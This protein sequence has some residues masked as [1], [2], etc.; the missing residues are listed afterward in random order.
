MSTVDGPPAETGPAQPEAEAPWAAPGAQ[1]PGAQAPWAAPGAQP[2]W[3]APGAPG[4]WGPG[5]TWGP[6]GPAGPAGP[7][8]AWGPGG[9]GGAGDPGSWGAEPGGPARRPHRRRNAVV[10]AGVAGVLAAGGTAWAVAASAGTPVLSTAVIASK[11]DPGLVDVVSTLGYQQAT[12]EG[13]GMVLTSTGEVLTNNHV[14]SGATSIKVI[15]IGNGRTYTAKVVG[16]SESNDVAVL[17]LQNASGLAT[18]SPGDSSTVR[19]G[20]KVVALGNA[21]GKGGTPSVATGT[22]SSLGSSITAVDSGDGVS[23]HLSGMIRSDAGIEP[24]DSGGPLVNTAGQVIG[25]DTAASTSGAEPGATS[26]TSAAASSSTEAFSIPINEALSVA[27][28]IAAGQSSATVHIGSTAFLGVA[29]A[30]GGQS[31][32][33]GGQSGAFGGQSGEFGGQAATGAAVEGSLPGTAAAQAGLGAGD[34]ITSL[35]GRAI[36][37]QSDL[38]S[39]VEAYHPG[40]KVSVSWTDSSGQAQTATVVLTAGPAG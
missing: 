26:A 33:F 27:G 2:P 14:I 8:G 13:T 6:G 21:E 39:A 32:A 12:S 4:P 34:V 37:S 10:A 20:Q 40:S 31:G 28:Q 7:A 22:V 3:A 15:D 23:E 38:Q 5:G 25:M 36:S 9:P 24:G 19:A 18:V 1:A 16:Y 29:V 35:G 30:S 17:Q 11:T